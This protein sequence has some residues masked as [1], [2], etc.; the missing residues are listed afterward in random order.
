MVNTPITVVVFAQPPDK[1]VKTIPH[2]RALTLW[3]DYMGNPTTE[4]AGY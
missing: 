1:K 4:T 2:R 3:V